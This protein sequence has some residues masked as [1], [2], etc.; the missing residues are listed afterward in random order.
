MDL[1]QHREVHSI[2][3]NNDGEGVA[4]RHTPNSNWAMRP[5]A[6]HPWPTLCPVA[7]AS[8]ASVSWNDQLDGVAALRLRTATPRPS[9]PVVVFDGDDTLW[10]TEHLYDEARAAAGHVVEATGLS[11]DAWWAEQLHIDVVNTTRFGLRAERF[12]TS[13]VEAYELLAEASGQ[14]PDRLVAERVWEEAVGVFRAV[15]PLKPGVEATLEGLRQD[16]QLVLLTQGDPRVQVKRLNDSGLESKFDE[17]VIVEKKSAA[18]LAALLAELN[19]PSSRA[20]MVGNSVP[21]DVNPALA[22]GMHA[23]WIDAHVWQHE[24]R[25]S[26]VESSGLVSAA[27]ISDV[28]AIVRGAR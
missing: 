5:E 8:L 21:S 26:V 9:A 14:Q 25:E 18:V 19:V 2:D 10:S 16:H 22:V 27:R 11:F 3:N 13:C 24:R 7:L 20:W 17:V 4:V 6:E 28:P 15:A 1:A 12:P 23:I